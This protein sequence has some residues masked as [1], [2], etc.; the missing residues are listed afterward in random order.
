VFHYDLQGIFSSEEKILQTIAAF[1]PLSILVFILLQVLQVIITPI[2]GEVT[3]LIGG[4]LYGPVLGTAYSTIGLIIGSCIAFSLA[5]VYG[6]PFI[7]KIISPSTLRRYDGFI[8][9]K[10][11]LLCFLFFIIPGMPKDIMCYLMGLSRMPIKNFMVMTASGRLLGTILLSAAG[12][13]LRNH[14]HDMLL[15]LAGAAGVLALT[16]YVFN[17][18]KNPVDPNNKK[19]R[20]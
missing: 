7:E 16:A 2:P 13:S 9:K 19:C 12:S 5:R 15:I 10:G 14:R 17:Y 4:Y 20:F 3:G 8:E 6:L 1:G 18:Y 11:S